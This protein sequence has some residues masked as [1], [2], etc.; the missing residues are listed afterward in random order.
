MNTQ[1]NRIIVRD[2]DSTYQTKR[3]VSAQIKDQDTTSDFFQEENMRIMEGILRLTY[4]LS[5]EIHLL[6]A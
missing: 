5:K 2:F 4:L 3:W 6:Y 1:L